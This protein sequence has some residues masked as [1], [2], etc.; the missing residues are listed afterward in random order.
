[1]RT[2]ST[3]LL[4]ASLLVASAS[5]VGASS[6]TSSTTT[7]APASTAAVSQAAIE[8]AVTASVTVN[9]LPTTLTPTLAQI[10]TDSGQYNAQGS[11]LGAKC[12]PYGNP[13]LLTKPV[14]C[15]LGATTSSKVVVVF[16]DSN[17]GN[18]LPAL[19]YAM[20]KLGYKLD[21]FIFPGCT[22][23]ILPP[24][25]VPT[26]A[27][28]AS[29]APYHANLPAAVIA[30]HP[31]ALISAQL[32]MDGGGANAA[33]W[34]AYGN[35]WKYTFDLLSGGSKSIKRIIMG[36]TP[37]MGGSTN[38]GQCVAVH[39]TQVI[40]TCS[41]SYFPTGNYEW[42]Y[43]QYLNRDATAASVAGATLVPSF[44]WFCQYGQ[45]GRNYCPTVIKNYLVY[46]DQDHVSIAYMDYIAP[47]VTQALHAQGL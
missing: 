17:A 9:K 22:S 13:A 26:K 35:A 18:W 23:Q 24:G 12:D 7:T 6:S 33:D 8:Q 5:A 4:T 1:M 40:S 10:A 2:P 20:S 11:S 15:I 45:P 36:T 29:C 42:N 14:P 39:P 19:D 43:Q 44:K 37:N 21:A 38:M 41:P 3:L 16:G 32:G 34:T 27:P 47:I 28:K 30:V 25:V 31:L 46:V